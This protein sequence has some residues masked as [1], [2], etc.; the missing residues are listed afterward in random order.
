MRRRKSLPAHL[1]PIKRHFTVW[2]ARGISDPTWVTFVRHSEPGDWRY[3]RGEYQQLVG[4]ALAYTKDEALR[5]V[6]SGAQS[7][8]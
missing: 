7:S 5:L 3:A 2:R 8:Q 1:Q 6:E 4:E